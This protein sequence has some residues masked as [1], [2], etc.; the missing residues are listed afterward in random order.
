MSLASL[1]NLAIAVGG[2]ITLVSIVFALHEYVR[3]G[4]LRRADDFIMLRRRL[5]ENETF[6]RICGLLER[7]EPY[8]REEPYENK[9]DLVGL[10]EEVALIMNS[11]LMRKKVAHYMF[12]S[13]AID[14][15][16]SE[17]FW[18]GMNIESQYWSLFRDF[19]EKMIEEERNFHFRASDYRL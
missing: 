18:S 4:T 6:R 17:N 16:R 1:A 2:V 9:R 5:K 14:C 3:N 10:F 8:L 12:G 7:D 13:Y 15:Y 19:A 11:G